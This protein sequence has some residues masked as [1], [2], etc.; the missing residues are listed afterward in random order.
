MGP[1]VQHPGGGED[2]MTLVEVMVAM[3]ILLVGVLG[4][5]TLLGTG[6]RITNQNL[7]RD[8]ATALARE[9]IERAREVAYANLVDPANVASA[10][11]T[12]VTGSAAS[13]GATFVTT[14]RGTSYTTV[15][16]TCVLDD[17]SD[18]IGVAQGTPCKPLAAGSGGGGS[19]PS[20][21]GST[22][23]NLNVLGIQ[24]TGG[25]QL[26]EAVCSLFGTRGSVL[27]SLLGSG[28]ALSGLVS[29]G[30]DTTFCA[31]KGNVAFDRQAA[32]ATA[33]TTTVT[34]T[35]AGTAGAGTVRQRT[36]VSGPR[37]TT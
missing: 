10:L 34:W 21:G 26:V 1:N 17:P 11:S 3:V 35:Y 2:G 31:G 37:V 7:S 9:Q 28:S 33:I 20:G 32:D 4:V 19:S 23:L 24:I 15:I 16:Q 22:S 25:G 8:A 27:D 5:V 29:S 30:A 36:V 13:T 14:R 18:G 12:V 6:N